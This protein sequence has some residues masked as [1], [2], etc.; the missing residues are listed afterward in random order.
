[1][2]GNHDARMLQVWDEAARGAGASTHH[3]AVRA[4]GTDPA[5]RA[6]LQGLPLILEAPRWI[7]VHGGL[8][9]QS[10]LEGTGRAACLN[11]RRWPDDRSESNPFWWEAWPECAGRAERR[12]VVYGHDAVRGLQDRRPAT[13]GLDSGCVYGGSLTGWIP[14]QDRILQVPAKKVWTQPVGQRWE[15]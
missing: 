10:G 13:L 12:T 5:V 4:L 7:V 1:V 11:L 8:H 6:W 2:L 15:L 3:Q 9:P 14:E